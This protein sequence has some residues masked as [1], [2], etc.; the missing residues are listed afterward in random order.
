MPVWREFIYTSGKPPSAS[1]F[2]IHLPSPL[3]IALVLLRR[4]GSNDSTVR[5]SYISI[6]NVFN[7]N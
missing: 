5:I 1:D 3:N 6:L 2:L 7:V 4:H